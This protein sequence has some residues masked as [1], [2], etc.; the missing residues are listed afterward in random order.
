MMREQLTKMFGLADRNQHQQ[1][2]VKQLPVARCE[3]RV[4]INRDPYSMKIRL[5]SCVRRLR[6]MASYNRSLFVY[7]MDSM[8]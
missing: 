8:S 3:V 5:M 1:D 4:R 6:H 2:E 7:A